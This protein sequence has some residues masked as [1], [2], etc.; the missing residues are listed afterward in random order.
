MFLFSNKHKTPISTYTDSYRPPCSIKKTMYKQSSEPLW[1]ENKFVTKGLTLPPVQNPASQGEPEHLIKLDAQEHYR[2]TVD[3]TTYWTD[4]YCLSRSEEKYKPVFVNEDKYITWR[5]GPYNNAAWNKHSCYLP[6]L[7]RETRVE[8]SLNSLNTPYPLKP[9]SLCEFE[10]EMVANMP[11]RLPLYTVTG[12]GCFHGYYSPCSGCHYW[13]RGMDHYVDEASSIRRHLSAL[14][15]RA[16]RMGC[17]TGS[18]KQ[19]FCSSFSP[20]FHP[21]MPHTFICSP[22]WDTGH[23]VPTGGAQRGTYIIHPEFTSEAYSALCH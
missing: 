17:N 22:R 15:E 18:Q 16:V 20:G 10:R 11:H 21:P 5:T 2:N 3:A 19:V 23:F 12:R 6:L 14:G 1:K 4:K 8:T 9:T 7:P 13:L